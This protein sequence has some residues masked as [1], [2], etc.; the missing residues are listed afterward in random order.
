MVI[1]ILIGV[2]LPTVGGTLATW[3]DSETMAGNYIETGSLDLLVNGQD[4]LPWGVGL[5]SCFDIPEFELGVTYAC[6]RLLWNAGCVDGVAYL[7]IKDV[8]DNNSLSS[9][10]IMHIWYDDVLVESDT[11]ANLDC[12]QIELGLLPAEAE[13]QLKLEIHADEGAPGDVLSFDI[14][15]ELIQV[16]LLE[17]GCGWADTE[18]SPNQLTLIF[19]GEGCTP[20]FWQG[21]N[22]EKLWNEP[23]DPDWTDAGGEGSNPY[24]WTTPFNSF[25][26]SHPDLDD[27]TMMDLVGKGGG[28]N[29]V[30]KA[31]R[32]LVAA[33]LNASFGM[34]YPLTPG[35]LSSLWTAAV[36][37]GSDEAF[38]ALHLELDEYNNYG[39]DLCD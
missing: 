6:Y 33:Y 14:A 20:G 3:S 11:I 22:G 15:F 25:F 26:T 35:E 2:A 5:E 18:K 24:I 9:N 28:N 21:G 27:L 34:N 30:R 23:N 38:M 19:E 17:R 1:L 10:T 8:V 16:E 29:D 31:A 7:H 39:C 36:D 12:R 37:D 13:R 32:S 4:D